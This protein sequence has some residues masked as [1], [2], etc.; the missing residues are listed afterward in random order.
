MSKSDS[1]ACLLSLWS[2]SV[3]VVSWIRLS[4]DLYNVFCVL[5]LETCLAHVQFCRNTLVGV[6]TI[7]D[8]QSSGP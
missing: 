7:G 2:G 6:T 8:C 1:T 4:R 5:F 3:L